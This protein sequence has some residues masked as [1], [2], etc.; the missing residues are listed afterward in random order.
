M[1]LD[2][3]LFRPVVIFSLEFCRHYQSIRCNY[4]TVA[5]HQ[6]PLDL[7]VTLRKLTRLL[8]HVL[9]HVFQAHY[10]AAAHLDLLPYL[11]TVTYHVMSF[12]KTFD[13][14]DERELQPL[15]DLH[16][17]LHHA[18]IAAQARAASQRTVFVNG[19]LSPWTE[20]EPSAGHTDEKDRVF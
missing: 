18:A 7:K 3:V 5:G 20:D 12:A 11:N 9:A 4:T 10:D 13:M 1:L 17:K 16:S 8:F 14:L 2:A 19:S 15:A 6:F